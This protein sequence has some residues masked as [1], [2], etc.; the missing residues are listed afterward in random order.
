MTSRL[1][2]EAEFHN[3]ILAAE[4]RTELG[5]FYEAAA[6]AKGYYYG[7]VGKDCAGRVLEYGCGRGG[8]IFDLARR[9]VDVVGIDISEEGIGLAR[10]R[11][12]T[13]GLEDKVGFRVMN[14][15]AP[16]FPDDHFDLVYGSGILHHL[17]LEAALPELTR[18][19]KPEGRAVFFEPLGHN[20][21]INIYR[22][23]TPQM[24]SQDEHPLV[25]RDLAALTKAFHRTSF[26]YFALCVLAAVPFRKWPGYR[27]GLRTL[28]LLD[29]AVLRLPF[30]RR[31]AWLVVISM[32]GPRKGQ[33]DSG[34]TL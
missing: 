10:Q 12:V 25:A 11:A 1:R 33:R 13:E 21:L 8:Y 16:D 7:L 2:R 29:A 31:Q 14:A 22:K 34:S 27:L 23:L 4:S 15:E 18:V 28:E 30:L 9:G 3:Q 6:T 19:I 17:D 26:S 20:I 32:H 5:K 24:R